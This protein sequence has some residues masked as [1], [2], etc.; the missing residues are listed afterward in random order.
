[1]IQQMAATA[2]D[3]TVTMQ[4]QVQIH[5]LLADS[6]MVLILVRRRRKTPWSKIVLVVHVAD[7]VETKAT[8]TWYACGALLYPVPHCR[9][10][11]PCFY[12]GIFP[13]CIFNYLQATASSTGRFF[14][15]IHCEFK[16]ISNWFQ[17]YND[18]VSIRVCRTGNTVTTTDGD[19][20]VKS[21]NSDGD[22]I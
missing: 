14:D 13:W 17:S 7:A 5:E 12:Q 16:P 6:V 1:M 11:A 2:D 22:A 20:I 15:D 10:G 21:N 3:H 8:M 4:A 19:N 18:I 9:S